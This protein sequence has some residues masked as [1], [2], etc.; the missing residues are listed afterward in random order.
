MYD[1]GMTKTVELFLDEDVSQRLNKLA[2]GRNSFLQVAGT[3]T[4]CI[5]C[6]FQ[7]AP[8]HALHQP[9]QGNDSLSQGLIMKIDIKTQKSQDASVQAIHTFE[10]IAREHTYFDPETSFHNPKWT[11]KN[12]RCLQ[13]LSESSDDLSCPKERPKWVLGNFRTLSVNRNAP[14]KHCLSKFY[15]LATQEQ[16]T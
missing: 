13:A 8:V 11:P 1:A 4:A 3:Y 7:L 9:A 16:P 10:P 14:R 5:Y 2:K 15:P 12:C 6:A